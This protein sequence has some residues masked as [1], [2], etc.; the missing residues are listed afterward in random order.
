MKPDKTL[1]LMRSSLL[2]FLCT[3]F[4]IVLQGQNYWS[5]KNV[6]SLDPVSASKTSTYELN[7]TGLLHALSSRQPI[8]IPLIDNKYVELTLHPCS[9]F[10]PELAAKYPGILSYCGQVAGTTVSIDVYNNKIQVFLLTNGKASFIEPD[11]H[12]SNLYHLSSGISTS[13]DSFEKFNCQN[14][15]PAIDPTQLN[16]ANFR[17]IPQLKTSLRTYRLALAVTGEFART[18]GS[19]KEAVIAAVNAHL[20]RINTVYRIEHGIQFQLV[21]NN[22]TLI[23]MDPDTDPYANGNVNSML[24]QNPK[25]L[26]ERIGLNNYDI[27]H[28]FG[29]NAGGVA[30]LNSACNALK[31]AGVSCTFGIF[32]GLQFYL[33]PC[34]EIGHQFSATHIFNFCDNDNET[35]SS[36]YEPG[37]GSTIMS[38]AGAS[39]CGA[40]YVQ[41]ISDPYFHVFS[42]QQVKT[43]SRNGVGALC[44]TDKVST[45]EEPVSMISQPALTTIPISTPFELTG[46]AIDDTPLNLSYTWEEMDLGQ[47]SPLGA[48]MGT[49]PLFRSIPPDSMT[50]RVFPR[51]SS[52]LNNLKSIT[53]VLPTI[54]RPLN[55]RF[56]VRDN[57][58]TGGGVHWSE[59]AIQSTSQ[60]GPFK[61]NSFNITDTVFRSGLEYISWQVANTETAP[62]NTKLVNIYLSDEGGLHYPVLLKSQT[63]NDGGE[64]VKFPD[65]AINK[66]RIKI[67]GHQNVFFDLNDADLTILPTLNSKIQLAVYPDQQTLCA[68]T[69]GFF[70][71]QSGLSL[72]TDSLKLSIQNT[73]DGLIQ[74]QPSRPFIRSND[75]LTI[76]LG[77]DLNAPPGRYDLVLKSISSDFKDTLE[78]SFSIKVV[79][80]NVP[81]L[82]PK[83][84]EDQVALQP[85]FKWKSPGLQE[86]F[87]LELATD[88]AFKK[89]VW[90]KS[91]FADSTA[92]PDSMLM[93][94]TIYFWRIIPENGCGSSIIPFSTFHTLALA[95]KSFTAGDTPKFISGTGTPTT[96]SVIIVP[97]II[98]LKQ[99]RIPGLAGSHDFVGDLDVQ[100]LAPSGDS[101]ILWSRQCNNLSNFNL[102]LDDM[103]PIPISCPLTDRKAHQPTQAFM[104]LNSSASKGNWILKVRDGMNGAGG[105][106]DGWSLELCGA[107][108]GL[109]PKLELNKTTE[110]AELKSVQI[111]NSQLLISDQDSPA[112]DIK[113]QLLSV[114]RFG[115]L[116]KNGQDT[117]RLGDVFSQADVNNGLI[118]FGAREVDQDTLD[119]FNFLAYDE[120]NNWTGQQ[121]FQLFI[122]NESVSTRPHLVAELPVKWF[123]NPASEYI[124]LENLS[125]ET[126]LLNCFTLEGKLVFTR[127][128]GVGFKKRID[129]TMLHEGFYLL[130]FI[131]ENTTMTRKLQVVRP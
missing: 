93:G 9:N 126:L 25:T 16:P 28:V 18:H 117:I 12:T 54:T 122:R 123:P 107:V 38:Y 112:G 82:S 113:I 24:E 102:S 131:H 74:I 114:P 57:D 91:V 87:K 105:S 118:R 23:F 35:S 108:E 104:R 95:C 89:I 71:I 33:I 81:L 128:L 70:K 56:T 90:T 30:L 124:L 6:S 1:A 48:P 20:S 109:G 76:Q 100:L 26:N 8:T 92:I 36:A 64:W 3:T 7:T 101:I 4:T 116:L 65:Y 106:L 66:A 72:S 10:S 75:S 60:S 115:Y 2:L 55:F 125:S 22:D 111:S 52:V 27:G 19:T 120:K 50:T 103:A 61:V 80:G 13:T 32:S 110:V 84:S 21:P 39:N 121:K 73:S 43:Y 96:S 69:T 5:L 59:L 94:N 83:N 127:R 58:P 129:I 68:G 130:Q 14:Q 99:I 29:T 62:V 40:N 47:K 77:V 63:P 86:G 51:L 119:Q 49:A 98:S 79:S 45:N 37:S 41:G 46:A 44:G 53:E 11:I 78:I 88:P 67:K 97:D 85:V 31:G 17:S 34:H 15:D 42:L